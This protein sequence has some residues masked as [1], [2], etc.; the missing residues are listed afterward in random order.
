M[1]R[2]TRLSIPT[3]VLRAR[4][5]NYVD[6]IAQED[7]TGWQE[8]S[9]VL[10]NE[11]VTPARDL[12]PPDIDRLVVIPDDALHYLPFETLAHDGDQGQPG[13]LE[14][15]AS[16]AETTKDAGHRTSGYLLEEFTISYAPSATVLA[17]LEEQ[18]KSSESSRADIAV[19]A[20]PQLA[21]VLLA[22][23]QTSASFG[24]SLYE[25]EGLQVTRIPFSAT[26][27][28]L[29]GSYGGPGSRTYTGAY[30]SENRIKSEQL[31]RFGVIHFATH[32]L[33]SQRMPARSALVLSPSDEDDGFLQLREIYQLKLRADLVVLSACQTARGQFLGGD[34]VRGLAQAFIHA[35]ASSVLASLWDVNDER[36]SRFMETFY[37]HLAEH[38]SKAEALRATK[39]ELI[40][41]DPASSPRQWAAFIL[42]GEPDGSVGI[43]R[44][45][46]PGYWLIAGIACLFVGLI[47]F[48][49]IRR[50]SKRTNEVSADKFASS[51]V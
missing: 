29:V 36:T 8:V 26:E 17:E 3:K 2:A 49:L 48:L 39:L 4:V 40:R 45:S 42:I 15:R 19:F 14:D 20:D 9:R 11:L 47:A 30:A 10:Y 46:A 33:I 31:E 16:G 23:S 35:G 43:G 38:R 25:E 1:F 13:L 37:R 21:P 28:Q 12:L 44:R 41:R 5:Q 7:T 34:G 22:D 51:A 32:G 18:A 27:A 24:R 50:R 6:L